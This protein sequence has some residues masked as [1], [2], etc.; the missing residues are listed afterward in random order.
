MP[1]H[2]YHN[3]H[4]TPFLISFYVILCI[5]RK[6]NLICITKIISGKSHILISFKNS[7]FYSFVFP[8]ILTSSFSRTKLEN[9][10][11]RSDPT[12]AS[13][14]RQRGAK[15]NHD[16]RFPDFFIEFYCSA[17]HLS[18][19]ESI[20]STSSVI[21]VFCTSKPSSTVN[22]VTCYGKRPLIT[23]F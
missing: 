18:F 7:R 2:E 5:I 20:G 1:K 21:S 10:W 8:H 17:Y 11:T 6:I 22:Q 14:S 12:V 19:I 15:K 4:I 16:V 23:V 13:S 3:N 9:E